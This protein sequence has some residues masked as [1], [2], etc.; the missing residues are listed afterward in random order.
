MGITQTY[1][2]LKPSRHGADTFMPGD[3]VRG[4]VVIFIGGS[5][6][7]K[8]SGQVRSQSHTVR[9]VH[10]H[11]HCQASPHFTITY[12]ARSGYKHTMS[13][14]SKRTLSH[15][16]R[17]VHIQT[18]SYVSVQRDLQPI[19]PVPSLQRCQNNSATDKPLG[20]LGTWAANTRK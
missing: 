6:P 2:V 8:L 7:C 9:S 1:I 3:M 20:C 12:A 4:A 15:A 17:S 18:R 11:T 14:W 16:V 5:S 13:G 10:S 19:R